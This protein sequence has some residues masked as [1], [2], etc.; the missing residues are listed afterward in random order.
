MYIWRPFYN[1]LPKTTA[2][3]HW[4]SVGNYQPVNKVKHFV[5][6]INKQTLWVLNHFFFYQRLFAFNE[7]HIQNE[8]QNN[9]GFRERN[10]TFI[11]FYILHTT[12]T[13]ISFSKNYLIVDDFHFRCCKHMKFH[14]N[15]FIV[16]IKRYFFTGHK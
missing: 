10:I 4:I 11:N 2:C 16:A 8:I 9:W 12:K 1:S 14:T 15:D 6:Y 3:V 7:I 5:I 13:C